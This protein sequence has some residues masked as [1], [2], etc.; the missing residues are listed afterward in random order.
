MRLRSNVLKACK[1]ISYCPAKSDLATLL[2]NVSLAR[3]ETKTSLQTSSISSNLNTMAKAQQA[4]LLKTATTAVTTA[5]ECLLRHL[6]VSMMSMVTLSQVAWV[7]PTTREVAWNQ[8]SL[9]DMALLLS[10]S[11]RCMEAALATCITCTRCL[12]AAT[13][14]N[15][16]VAV[17]LHLWAVKGPQV[18]SSN[19]SLGKYL[20]SSLSHQ[21]DRPGVQTNHLATYHRMLTALAHTVTCMS[22]ARLV[23][24]KIAITNRIA[25]HLCYLE[26]R[27]TSHRN[28]G[29]LV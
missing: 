2:R 20:D 14:S 13:I 1:V 11:S 28:S 25:V 8:T 23:G 21:W 16:W 10:I 7:C 5:V 22:R 19:S 12:Q 9:T 27:A 18:A 29:S 24:K 6:K 4:E 17:I 26:P 15:G 3:I